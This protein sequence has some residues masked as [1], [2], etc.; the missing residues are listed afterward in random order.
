MQSQRIQL[1]GLFGNL[2]SLGRKQSVGSRS[3]LSECRLGMHNLHKMHN[4]PSK[5]ID[6][7]RFV[8]TLC[9]GSPAKKKLFGEYA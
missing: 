8:E 1:A 6:A 7:N 2:V 4:G 3:G 5:S 9:D